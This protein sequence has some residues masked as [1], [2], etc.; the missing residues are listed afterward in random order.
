[1]HIPTARR[2]TGALD[3][4]ALRK[5]LKEL[6]RRHEVLRTTFSTAEGEARQ[7]IHDPAPLPLPV[8]HLSGLPEQEREA[9]ARQQVTEEARRPFDLERG[10]LFRA[11][12]IRLGEKDH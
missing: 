11:S 5:S 8:I 6:V 2:L 4:A 10:P 1:Y 12:L 7:V 3:H 9:R